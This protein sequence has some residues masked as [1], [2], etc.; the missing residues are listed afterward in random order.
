MFLAQIENAKLGLERNTM[1]LLSTAFSYSVLSTTNNKSR[2]VSLVTCESK[3]M[4][5]KVK[6]QQ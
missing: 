3:K 6:P 5:M 2:V 4:H 1:Y